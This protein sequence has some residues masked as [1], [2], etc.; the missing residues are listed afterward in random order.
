MITLS[1]QPLEP[2]QTELLNAAVEAA[3]NVQRK[4]R[5]KFLVIETMADTSIIHP[6]LPGGS[7]TV[8]KGDIDVLISLGLLLPTY[9][10][11]ST[12]FF[13]VSPYGFQFYEALKEQSGK[14][15]QRV[16][17][18]TKDFIDSD[19][20]RR[21]Y[22]LAYDKWAKAE[23]VLWSSDSETQFTT[24]G[25]L[26]REALQEFT[27]ALV[28]HYQLT[29]SEP[30]KTHT[31]AR[32]RAI[33]NRKKASLGETWVAFLDALLAYW[34]TLNDLVQKQ[35]HGSLKEGDPL[36]WEDGRRVVFH[37]A[38]LMSEICRCFSKE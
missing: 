14:P 2:E 6:G 32:L 19:G 7:L 3:R 37:T 12:M 11:S 15:M 31:V 30:D 29:D 8:Y 10:S 26:C 16:G 22:P 5:Q 25:H 4:E 28:I 23:A 27:E 33:I 13:D 21:K 1:P 34:G 24:I 17:Q 20:F 36:I 38:V 9:G 35:E 18:Q